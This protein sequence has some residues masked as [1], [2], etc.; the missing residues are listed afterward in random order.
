MRT[1]WINMKACVSN[2]EGIMSP[3]HKNKVFILAF[4]SFST[5]QRM[6]G[7]DSGCGARIDATR[8]RDGVSGLVWHIDP[9]LDAAKWP[10]RCSCHTRLRDCS[11]VASARY[12][13]SSS[14][15]FMLLNTRWY[16]TASSV[17]VNELY[18]GSKRDEMVGGRHAVTISEFAPFFLHTAVSMAEDGE[19]VL[20]MSL[21]RNWNTN[22]LR[23]AGG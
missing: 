6:A 7:V 21:A 12:F 16:S 23:L 13:A 1:E 5:P 17:G 19:I 4:S 15:N 10:L 14:F 11:F 8:E 9:N 3:L 22:F 20:K 2:C 18:F